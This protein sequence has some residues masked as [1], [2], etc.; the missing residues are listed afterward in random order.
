M[1][2]CWRTRHS[3][4][5][6]FATPSQTQ[7]LRDSDPEMLLRQ[8]HRVVISSSPTILMASK[9]LLKSTPLTLPLRL[10][11]SSPITISAFPLKSTSRIFPVSLKTSALPYTSHSNVPDQVFLLFSYICMW[12]RALFCSLELL[13][14]TNYFLVFFGSWSLF[15]EPRRHQ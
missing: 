14:N 5:A 10:N 6:L 1:E 11:L 7:G 4:D 3:V 2:H 13:M 15:G 9:Q 8:Q 12:G